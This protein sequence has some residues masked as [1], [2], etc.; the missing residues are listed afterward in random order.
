M[1]KCILRL[2]LD[3]ALYDEMTDCLLTFPQRQLEF[4]GFSVQAHTR[5][6]DDIKEQVSGFKKKMQIEIIT[7]SNEAAVIY[8]H[9]KTNLN[10]AKFDVVAY[11][12][13]DFPSS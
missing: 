3:S 8:S 1:N 9:I 11:P 7:D 13:L 2:T 5:E 12:L 10:Q 4:N 6:L